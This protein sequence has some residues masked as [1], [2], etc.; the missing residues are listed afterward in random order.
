MAYKRENWAPVCNEVRF[1]KDRSEGGEGKS[2][3]VGNRILRVVAILDEKA[4][5]DVISLIAGSKFLD[6][7]PCSVY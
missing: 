2:R 7:Y 1:R 3:G 5:A 6:A 4:L